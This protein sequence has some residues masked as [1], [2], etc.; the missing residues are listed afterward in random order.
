MNTDRVRE[1]KAYHLLFKKQKKNNK[2]R[3]INDIL[4]VIL[5]SI[6]ISLIAHKNDFILITIRLEIINRPKLLCF[7]RNINWF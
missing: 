3:N 5:L 2:I 6:E 7:V 4:L 1:K